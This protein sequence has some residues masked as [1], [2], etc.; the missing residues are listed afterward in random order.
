MVRTR[1][2]SLRQQDLDSIAL[3][4]V[5]ISECSEPQQSLRPIPYSKSGKMYHSRTGIEILPT[6]IDLDSEDDEEI[7]IFETNRKRLNRIDT[8]S[9]KFM[10]IWNHFMLENRNKFVAEKH[11]LSACKEFVEINSKKIR[12]QNL[13]NALLTH[14]IFFISIGYFEF[15]NIAEILQQ[16]DILNAS[17]ENTESNLFD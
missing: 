6:E 8:S 11:M 14:L 12:E 16:F 4:P 9:G 2:S 17:K 5:T 10:K 7:H 15:E 3:E 13:E 1:S